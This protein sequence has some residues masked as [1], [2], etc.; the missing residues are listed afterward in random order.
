MRRYFRF[1][2]CVTLFAST[3]AH[4]WDW[5]WTPATTTKTLPSGIQIEPEISGLSAEPLANVK[6]RLTSDIGNL[7]PPLD[8]NDASG[9]YEQ[10]DK[11][12]EN[13]LTPFG[14]FTPS[15]A[16][17][18]AIKKTDLWQIQYQIQPGPVSKIRVIDLHIIGAGADEPALRK[19][20]EHPPWQIGSPFSSASYE[21]YKDAL[22]ATANKL[23]Y[24]DAAFSDHR[25]LVN[26]DTQSVEI[27][28]TLD[29]QQSYVFGNVSFQKNPL[30][31]AFLQRFVPFKTGEKYT[32][33]LS[34]Q[35]QTNLT[36]SGYFQQITVNPELTQVTTDR[37]IP[38]QVNITPKPRQQY[39]FG[40]G[41]GTD[42][43]P[44]ISAG[45]NWNYVTDTGHQLMTMARLSQV[46][47]TATGKYTIP[48][49]NPLEDQ[50]NLNAS[51]TSNNITQG[52]SQIRQVGSGFSHTHNGWQRNLA[53]SYQ[54]ERYSFNQDPYQT[55]HLLLPSITFQKNESD[56]PLYPTRG[57]SFNFMLQGAA[58]N[59]AS[60][61]NLL[62]ARVQEKWLFPV[63]QKS[64][65]LLRTDL[66]YTAIHDQ[67]LLPLSLNFFAGGAQSVRGYGYNDLGP[68]R[69]LVVGSA[70]FR[71]KIVGD[72]YGLSFM[73][74]GNAFDSLPDGGESG[75]QSKL[76]A[77][78][79]M[80]QRG[81]GV[82]VGWNSPVGPMQLSLA[83]AVNAEGQPNRIQFS[84]GTSL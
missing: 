61:T 23:G 57:N 22:I 2:L 36:N 63:T 19:Q 28:L 1:S 4:A 41:Y 80:L 12:I 71:H 74:A 69:Y 18:L 13:G 6:T 17:Q 21:D 79:N 48:G 38:M 50:Y 8:H 37:A 52:N 14:Y 58:K 7:P 70:E 15:I 49:N 68:G 47:K 16:K 25:V 75:T 62:Q 51:L 3:L 46:Q 76:G 5:P 73:D 64:Q 83:K 82:G 66:G 35:L 53:L 42:T 10:S 65:I 20:L 84:M 59:M 27:H 9:F 34:E 81:V 32:P 24:I 40:G 77:I 78:Y 55:S 39:I 43:G 31:D 67:N 54:I 60:D 72:F 56:N 44:R 26:R 33:A 11:S 45:S 29:T 30:S